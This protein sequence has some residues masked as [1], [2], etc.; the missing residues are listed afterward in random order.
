MRKL[1]IV[2]GALVATALAVAACGSTPA[3]STLPTLPAVPSF[4]V[5]SIAIPSIAIPTLP[6][7][8]FAL[9]GFSFSNGDP[10]LTSRFPTQIA[11]QPVTNVYTVNFISFFQ[12]FGQSDPESSARLQAFV[13]LLASAGIDAT[14]VSFGSASV[15]VN[16][17][18]DQFQAFRT[19]G[20]DA[21][22]FVALY[23]QL[24]ALN[25]SDTPP[26]VVGTANIGG[27]SVSTFTDVST[28]TVTYIYPSG[29]V[30]WSMDTRFP[31]DA[32][33]VFGALQ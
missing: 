4:A 7:G 15:T 29:D 27:K 31:D 28:E 9:P 3:A 21:T 12:A 5:P 10:T 25:Q 1:S 33:A 16:G 22:K 30:V 26:P 13:Q 24:A 23:P 18:E 8:S 19:P 2:S 14:Q 32:A 20:S 6:V 11:G 17:D